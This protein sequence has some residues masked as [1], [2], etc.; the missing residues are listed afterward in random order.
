MEISLVRTIRDIYDVDISFDITDLDRNIID[1]N[2]IDYIIEIAKDFSELKSIVKSL[3]DPEFRNAW[4]GNTLDLIH[5]AEIE[6]LQ[7]FF[8]S[9]W[10]GDLT[11]FRDICKDYSVSNNGTAF[12]I[13]CIEE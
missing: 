3:C 6:N 10:S 13:E 11:Y 2:G 7:I 8:P 12:C 9:E 4:D 5:S 1:F